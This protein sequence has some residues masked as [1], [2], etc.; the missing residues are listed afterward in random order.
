MSALKWVGVVV[1]VPV[2]IVAGMFIKNKMAGPVGWAKDNVETA[3][4]LQMKDPDSMV[5][6]SS[7]VV[8]RRNGHVLEVSICGFVD[9]RNGF[10]AYSG[11]MR[12]ASNSVSN[13]RLRTFQTNLVKVENPM[14]T[15]QAHDVNMLSGFEEAYW[16]KY[17]VDSEHPALTVNN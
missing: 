6:R 11:P 16:N 1:L 8:S 15:K 2:A 14:E 17:C 4:S 10:G 7:F 3:L 9:G 5:I 12:F 13:G